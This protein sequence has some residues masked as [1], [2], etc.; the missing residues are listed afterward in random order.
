MPTRIIEFCKKTNQPV[1]ET[2]GAVIRCALDSLAMRYRW[3]AEHLDKLAGRRLSTIN[4]VGGGTQNTLL[5]QLTADVTGRTALAGPIEATA[6]GNVIVQA[7]GLGHIGSIS[8]AREIVRSSFDIIPY[9][10]QPNSRIDEAYAKFL[11]LIS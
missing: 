5:C 10:P 2:V 8:E 7:I 6:I 1:P 4:I 3:V 11:T 9:N